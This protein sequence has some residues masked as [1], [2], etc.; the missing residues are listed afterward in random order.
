MDKIIIIVLVLAASFLAAD[1]IEI[2][3]PV[4]VSDE[5]LSE[6][7]E[8]I[9]TADSIKVETLSDSMLMIAPDSGMIADSIRTATQDS[10]FV[11][12]DSLL[13]QV[14]RQDSVLKID[15]MKLRAEVDSVIAANEEVNLPFVLLRENFHL[16]SPNMYP[17][18]MRKNGFSVIPHRVYNYHVLQN[19]LPMYDAEY[20]NDV[21]YFTDPNYKLRSALT[22]TDFGVGKNDMNH[23]FASFRKGRI[24]DIEN[25]NMNIEILAQNGIWMGEYEKSQNVNFHLAYDSKMGSFHYYFF[26]VNQEIPEMKTWGQT[27]NLTEETITDHSIKWENK[28]VDVGLKS[29]YSKLGT[30]KRYLTHLLLSKKIVIGESYVRPS[31]EHI[32]EEGNDRTAINFDQRAKINNFTFS[33]YVHFTTNEDLFLA[34]SAEVLLIKNSGV[35]AVYRKDEYYNKIGAGFYDD[36]ASIIFGM[37]DGHDFVEV[38]FQPSFDYKRFRTS[39]DAKFITSDMHE[40]SLSGETRIDVNHGNAIRLGASWL[41]AGRSYSI[42]NAVS[43]DMFLGLSITKYFEINAIWKNVMDGDMLFDSPAEASRFNFTMKWIFVN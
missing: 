12:P 10:L 23:I 17:L 31:F 28:I 34:G 26:N 22:F 18:V 7:I 33:N 6:S 38:I 11:L 35:K 13:I 14:A 30:D 15:L 5:V 20:L 41:Y 9:N 32:L 2:N 40:I 24:M 25:L 19:N 42:K 27:G 43:F 3:Q 29:E 36:Y 37:F 8:A 21:L 1:V 4:T 39:F 16:Y